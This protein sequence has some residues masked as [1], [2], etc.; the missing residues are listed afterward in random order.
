MQFLYSLLLTPTEMMCL[1][2]VNFSET[3]FVLPPKDPA[4]TAN[5]RIFMTSGEAPFAGHPNVGTATVLAWKGE[6]FGKQIGDTMVFEEI[7]GLVNITVTK[8]P[9]G[10]AVGATLVAPQ[11]FQ[12]GAH[13]PI[14]AVA[15]ALCVDSSLI[16]TSRH[17]PVT[18]SCGLP[19]VLAELKDLAALEQCQSAA[20]SDPCWSTLKE[21]LEPLVHGPIALPCI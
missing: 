14:T 17:L 3:T 18:G 16:E 1:A 9:V 19:F 12:Q 15:A 6:L 2:S 20:A 7:A 21:V 5:V 13:A 10:N 11:I 4:N 8:D